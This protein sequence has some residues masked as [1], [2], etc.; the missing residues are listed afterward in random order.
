MHVLCIDVD[1]GRRAIEHAVPYDVFENG[2]MP[3]ATYYLH[4]KESIGT[5]TA[6]K[7]EAFRTSSIVRYRKRT[8]VLYWNSTAMNMKYGHAAFPGVKER[9]CW[10]RIDQSNDHWEERM[11]STHAISREVTQIQMTFSLR[12]IKRRG[13]QTRQDHC[14]DIDSIRDFS[15]ESELVQAENQRFA[16]CTMKVSDLSM[17][18]LLVC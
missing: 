13:Y 10:I 18:V 14:V 12:R 6:K 2:K 1:D 15:R 4:S 16:I 7:Y 17:P 5:Y 9:E 11:Q 3:N 8:H